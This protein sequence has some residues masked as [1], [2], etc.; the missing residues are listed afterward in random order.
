MFSLFLKESLTF[1]RPV[2]KRGE[3]KCGQTR[4]GWRRLLSGSG[5]GFI[6]S[7]YCHG[8]SECD[9]EAFLA[10]SQMERFG[11][12]RAEP[13]SGSERGGKAAALAR[14]QRDAKS[15]SAYCAKADSE[16]PASVDGAGSRGHCSRWPGLMS[17]LGTCSKLFLPR[18]GPPII[19]LAHSFIHSFCEQFLRVCWV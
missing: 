4:R 15:P 1:H 14:P 3:Q 10:E 5:K 16:G 6:W 7:I 18:E 19:S 13:Q 8:N 2:S 11:E 9:F 12:K 17:T